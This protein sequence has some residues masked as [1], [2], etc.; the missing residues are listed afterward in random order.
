MK[1]EAV[2]PKQKDPKKMAACLC[3]YHKSRTWMS[4]WRSLGSH[5]LSQTTTWWTD[6]RCVWWAATF[7]TDMT[8]YR[9]Q[10]KLTNVHDRDCWQLSEAC[11]TWVTTELLVPPNN[12][13]LVQPPPLYGMPMLTP[14]TNGKMIMNALYHGVMYVAY[15]N[16][17]S[18]F[19][20]IICGVPQGSILGPLLF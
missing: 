9:W 14:A 12:W 7:T 15:S 13:R 17:K 1:P 10:S 18:L 11:F 6:T 8:H 4:A 20:T 2:T 5:G 3:S 16:Y 19:G